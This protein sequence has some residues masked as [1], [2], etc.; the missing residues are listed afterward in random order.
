MSVPDTEEILEIAVAG[1]P[2]VARVIAAIPAEHW[3]EAL[4]A[5]ERSYLRTAR[6]LGYG[7][8]TAQ[9][10]VRAVM[11][12]LHAEVERA[13]GEIEAVKEILVEE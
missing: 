1:V 13:I 10:L 3:A 9:N 4:A 2:R 7:E 12:F 11:Q 8:V 6:D 5:A